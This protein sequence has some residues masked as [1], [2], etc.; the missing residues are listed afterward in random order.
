MK[1]IELCAGAGGTRAGLDVAGWKCQFS[2]DYDLSAVAA[3]KETYGD[4]SLAD[5]NEI[6]SKTL[7]AFDALVAGFP[8]Q[9][10]STSGPRL[11]FK[12]ES[13]NVFSSIAKIL[14]ERRPN[15]VLLENVQGLLEHNKGK[16]FSFILSSLTHL[17]YKVEWMCLD[18]AWFGIP[19]TRPRVFIIGIQ[20]NLIPQSKRK[21]STSSSIFQPISS[22]FKIE[23][24]D[25]ELKKID[26]IKNKKIIFG[27]WGMASGNEFS[28]STFIKPKIAISPF[29]LGKIVAPNFSKPELIR[30]VRYYARGKP[31]QL[32]VRAEALSHCLGNIPGGAPMFAVPLIAVKSASARKAFLE[33]TNWSREQDGYLVARLKPE[34]AVYLFGPHTNKLSA[35]IQR[36]ET[37]LTSKYMITGNLVS[38]L[39]VAEVAKVIDN[40][41]LDFKKGMQ[42]RRVRSQNILHNEKNL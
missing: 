18:T 29:K 2:A 16:T 12:H 38:P 22:K 5:V 13:G 23:L 37:T 9:P 34:H 4:I 36:A 19:Q 33:M 20:N 26:Q 17:N 39:C 3:H 35:G 40:A 28:T 27:R 32:H 30:S 42:Q 21:I 25:G 7:P 1:Y 11:G 6:D 41:L 24:S 31:T 10:F 14:D 15:V 8:C